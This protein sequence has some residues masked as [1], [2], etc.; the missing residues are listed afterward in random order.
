[1]PCRLSRGAAIS[2]RRASACHVKPITHC[3]TA[4]LGKAGGKKSIQ[5]SRRS[6]AVQQDEDQGPSN[7]GHHKNLRAAWWC[8]SNREPTEMTYP[9]LPT[10]LPILFI[11][12]SDEWRRFLELLIRA[13]WF[14]RP[15]ILFGSPTNENTKRRLLIYINGQ[16]G[17]VT[18]MASR[19]CVSI[20]KWCIGLCGLEIDRFRVVSSFSA[21][22]KHR[23]STVHVHSPHGSFRY[24]PREGAMSVINCTQAQFYFLQRR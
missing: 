15:I 11:C 23:L 8:T 1:M 13:S 6:N 7:V 21:L 5:T 16:A 3:V 20:G 14:R 9:T 12:I 22:T 24:V 4:T 19:T 10:I 17:H 18:G 2:F